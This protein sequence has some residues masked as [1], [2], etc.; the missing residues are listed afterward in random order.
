MSPP[1]CQWPSSRAT[2]GPGPGFRRTRAGC[3]APLKSHL[4]PPASVSSQQPKLLDLAMNYYEPC[5]WNIKTL[6][7][8]TKRLLLICSSFFLCRNLIGG[9]KL[10]FLKLIFIFYS[11]FYFFKFKIIL[12]LNI[13][14]L[15][16]Y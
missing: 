1:E 5:R 16:A 3:R 14:K 6:S 7:D 12:K 10:C 15:F 9:A 8:K 2:I 11:N 4:D 13:F